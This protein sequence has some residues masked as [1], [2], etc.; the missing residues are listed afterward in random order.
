[1]FGHVRWYGHIRKLPRSNAKVGRVR[2]LIE[3]VLLLA[4][5][6]IHQEHLALRPDSALNVALIRRKRDRGKYR[7]N[8]ER[9]HEFDQREAI[10]SAHCF[11]P[12]TS[13]VNDDGIAVPRIAD[14]RLLD[15]NERDSQWT[16]FRAGNPGHS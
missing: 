4:L 1:M 16:V 10:E 8:R 6:Q 15:R 11:L 12:L 7:N 3:K 9:H 14:R 5:R 2:A 13:H